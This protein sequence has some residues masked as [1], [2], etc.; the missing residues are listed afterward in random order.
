M[1]E[2]VGRRN[3]R[4][5]IVFFSFLSARAGTWNNLTAVLV[6][7]LPALLM[8]VGGNRCFSEK[9]DG[10]ITHDPMVLAGIVRGR[11]YKIEQSFLTSGFSVSRKAI[12]PSDVLASSVS[13]NLTP[14]TKKKK[15]TLKRRTTKMFFERFFLP[16]R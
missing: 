4:C 12:F 11:C 8:F 13:R 14:S 16:S 10:E 5:E 6:F 7:Q 3:F 9:C 15:F 2:L 1:V